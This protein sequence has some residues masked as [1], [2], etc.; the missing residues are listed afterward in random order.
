MDIKHFTTAVVFSTIAFVSNPAYAAALGNGA[1]PTGTLATP[2]DVD[3]WTF[4]AK[5][6]Q[7]IHVQ[8]A[9]LSG[10]DLQ[11]LL[12]LYDPSNVEVTSNWGQDS[13][14]LKYVAS[15]TGTYT[16]EVLDATSTPDGTGTYQMFLALSSGSFQIPAGDEG[17]S[18]ISGNKHSGNISLADLDI[19]TFS[20]DAMETVFLQIGETAT[21]SSGFQPE[22][23]VYDPFGKE[24]GS[25]WGNTAADLTF[26]S[27][28]AGQYTVVVKEST[29]DVVDTGSYDLY[30]T[31][32]GQP[33]ITPPGDH[34]GP[35]TNG[36]VHSGSID[37]AD[38]D[39]W[40]FS[41]E[42]NDTVLIQV[43]DINGD[44][45]FQPQ[46]SLFDAFGNEVQTN[47][48]N[49]AADL[50]VQL[51][52]GGQYT[53][54]VRESTGD[55]PDTGAY[56]LYFTNTSESL[57][58][59]A[60]DQGGVVTNGGVYDGEIELA[61]I[62]AWTFSG[63]KGNTVVIQVGE[64]ADH[65]SGF[66]PEV[67]LYDPL[68]NQL[69]LNW[70]NTA[71]D[72]TVA[73]PM[74]GEYT[75]V[76]KES[77]VDVP[78]SGSYKLYFNSVTEA[79]L[80]VPTGDEGGVLGNGS[81]HEGDIDLGD[82]DAWTFTGEVYQT[83]HLQ[84]AEV[85]DDT[86]GFQPE[87]RLYDPMG[88]LVTSN[89]GNVS[90]DI[91]AT[92]E[93]NGQYTVIV[94]E[95]SADVPDT[96]SYKLYFQQLAQ[97]FSV[98]GNDDGG[99]L[100]SGTP[101]AGTIDR[102]DLD[103][104]TFYVDAEDQ[105]DLTLTE[106]TD[107]GGFYPQITLYD[108]LG[109]PLVSG[110]GTTGGS[111]STPAILSG[112]YTAVVADGTGDVPNSG[113]YELAY[114][115]TN[116]ASPVPAGASIA[117]ID[118]GELISGTFNGSTDIDKYQLN[119]VAGETVYLRLGDTSNS[120]LNPRLRVF[121]SSGAI[122][123]SSV[124][125]T[126][127]EAE[128]KAPAND[129]L[130]VAVSND[131]TTTASYDYRLTAALAS[132]PIN[133][134]A[135]DIGGVISSGQLI[136]GTLAGGDAD[137]FNLTVSAGE[138]VYVR[139]GDTSNSYVSPKLRIY[140][141]NG[142]ILWSSSGSQWTEALFHAPA[143]ETLTIVASNHYA[144][145]SIYD[146]K[147]SAVVASQS[148][149][150]SSGD[151]GGLIHS[152]ELISGSF[153]GGD[154]D[155]FSLAVSAGEA[156][157]LRLGDTNNSYVNPQLMVLGANGNLL[158]ASSASHWTEALFEAP[159]TETLTIVAANHYAISTPYAYELTAVVASQSIT[160]SAGDES[161]TIVSGEEVAGLF[162]GGDADVFN[163]AVQA[164]ESVYVRL[165]DTNNSY[166]NPNLRIF[167]SSGQLLWTSSHS[168]WTEAL[169]KAPATETLTIVASN[170]YANS[171]DESYRLTAMAA[172]QAITTLVGDEGGNIDS[173][174]LVSGYLSGGDA[175]LFSLSVVAGEPVYLRFGDTNNSY[176]SPQLRIF[177]SSGAVLWSSANSHW[178]EA[179]FHA[180]ATENIR[181]LVSNGY[182]ISA[183]Y[184][185]ELTGAVA[186][187]AVTT[188][189]GDEG[190]T[191]T[192][193]MTLAGNFAGGDADVYKV[194]VQ[195]GV[196]VQIHLDDGGSSYTNPT[197]YIINSN[198]E[199]VAFGSTNSSTILDWVPT[200]N[201]VVTIIVANAYPSSANYGYNLTGTGISPF[202]PQLSSGPG[203]DVPLPL[204]ALLM[205]GG[206]V[207]WLS[208]R[209]GSVN[210]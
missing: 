60:G 4:S 83:V 67:S 36:G 3:S 180:P 68:G 140:R 37:L 63:E 38:I 209:Y 79:S 146:Y 16:V 64:V 31:S 184:E 174:E 167:S 48:G 104:W 179:L 41:A 96:G 190:G 168:H 88:N 129:T 21:S 208:K 142:D 6:G 151:E 81:V 103:A 198:R 139:L 177:S 204:W 188:L 91:S 54:I 35:L 29:A 43:A 135:G 100:F 194:I 44:A 50:K 121:S 101:Q 203:E 124:S 110:Q 169:L 108:P 210:A 158:W 109:R 197:L 1:S 131:Y 51:T 163:L 89:W 86:S 147:L 47:W 59:P 183:E 144:I 53:V 133:T 8:V 24:V 15:K 5:A 193:G 65:T 122:L 201:E 55:V 143:S 90:A 33:Y 182:S 128:F 14:D 106:L 57:V 115:R 123:W 186:S 159:L 157:Y 18:L 112:L 176:F 82:V 205:L 62:D 192:N 170:G 149:T 46:I 165:G 207:T 145:S 202:T 77:S 161:G 155:V 76:V 42:A 25:N 23:T 66:Q 10:T 58:V 199:L 162:A 19:W 28:L 9:E 116:V 39:A 7:S 45:G 185:Y 138:A 111:I 27:P 85:T 132:Q 191:L 71:A 152:G 172:S 56:Q 127:T 117:T 114:T 87:I 178:T 189:A 141:S 156:V 154:A 93:R 32:A 75:I 134:V 80:M 173:G 74:A 99:T 95:S 72:L 34:G 40:S 160:T 166:A 153:E 171:S 30:F 195:N 69:D 12:R 113:T 105:I 126:W 148:I 22:I 136:S 11:P 73:L 187:Q 120:Y 98:A 125:S 137:V 92:L 118:N 175:D 84:I 181:V 17:G 130:T 206:V 102:A 49:S 2:L 97:S 107:N 94:R 164:G 13:T 196:P 26:Q 61:D 78:D 119:V 70:G 200:H 52:K 150:T 20:V